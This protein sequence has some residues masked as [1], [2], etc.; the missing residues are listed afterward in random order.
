MT[1]D[2]LKPGMTVYDTHSYRMGN[3][4]MRTLGVWNIR[5]VS[6]NVAN[7]NVI[8]SWNGNPARI[9]FKRSWKK[10]RMKE[11]VLIDSGIMGQQRLA[12]RAELKEMKSNV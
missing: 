1:I 8:A 4:T 2:K 10:W 3:T 6:V 5:I 7:Q 9:Y 12:T 11:P